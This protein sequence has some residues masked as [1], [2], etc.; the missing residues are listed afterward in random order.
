MTIKGY[1]RFL[2]DNTNKKQYRLTVHARGDHWRAIVVDEALTES[3]FTTDHLAKDLSL[4]GA[5]QW[6]IK[7]ALVDA[8]GHDFQQLQPIESELEE[9]WK[10][11]D[12]LEE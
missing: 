4:E 7:K 8:H 9:P 5:K 2:Y 10:E 12:Q 11:C 1:R 6:A 3:T